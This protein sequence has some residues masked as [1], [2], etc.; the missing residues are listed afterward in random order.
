M[1]EIV[2]ETLG[3]AGIL[4]AKDEK[5]SVFLSPVMGSVVVNSITAITVKYLCLYYFIQK[6]TLDRLS[7]LSS[8][9]L[10]SRQ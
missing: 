10:S 8:V 7:R 2:I 9:H 6:N 1:F 3:F 4:S 5:K